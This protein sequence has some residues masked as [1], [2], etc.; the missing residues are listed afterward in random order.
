MQIL[1]VCLGNIC[2]S[3]MA[4]GVM[5]QKIEKYHLNASVD[6][7]GTAAYHVGQSPDIR[8]IQTLKKYNIDIAQLQGRQFQSSDFDTFDEIFVMDTENLSDILKKA[9]NQKEKEKVRLL[10]DEIHPGMQK[11]VPDPY[12][13]NLNDF[14]TTYELIEK[15]C[16]KIALRLSK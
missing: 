11:I 2:R 13:G 8:G 7:C 14:E 10:M 3:P 16:E 5:R 6:S 1:M 12:Y 4:E 15:A 9:R